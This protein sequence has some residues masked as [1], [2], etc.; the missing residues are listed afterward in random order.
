MILYQ[1]KI[2]P[3]TIPDTW[4][5]Q[6]LLNCLFTMTPPLTIPIAHSGQITA[7]V[8]IDSKT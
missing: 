2:L 4:N 8:Y 6:S 5:Q 7:R 1:A 3:C